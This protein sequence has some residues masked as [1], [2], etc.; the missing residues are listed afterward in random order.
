MIVEKY[1]KQ[2]SNKRNMNTNESYKQKFKNITFL[3][4]AYLR[5]IMIQL[6]KNNN[7]TVG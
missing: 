6:H 1:E 7:N 3:K 4:K 2:N 5:K